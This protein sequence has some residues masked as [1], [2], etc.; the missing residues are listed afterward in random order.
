MHVNGESIVDL[1]PV[2]TSQT[3]LN[4]NLIE[5][6]IYLLHLIHKSLIVRPKGLRILLLNTPQV[7][8]RLFWYYCRSKV[9]LEKATQL[10]KV[11]NGVQMKVS[12]P[13]LS[14]AR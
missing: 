11:R 4:A 8:Q 10:S 7:R 2:E 9:S 5:K 14:N 12:V 13:S 6:C 1:I 3:N